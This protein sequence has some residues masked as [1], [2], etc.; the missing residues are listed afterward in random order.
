MNRPSK[1]MVTAAAW[2][3]ALSVLSGCVSITAPVVPP[4]GGIYTKTAAPLILPQS[5]MAAVDLRD[6]SAEIYH[7]KIPIDY[8]SALS[9]LSAIS[10]TWDR[11][12]L[13]KVVGPTP[14]ERIAFADYEIKSVLGVY[15]EMKVTVYG[16]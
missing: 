14:F 12:D 13:E 6:C 2:S 15:A 16:Q 4:M 9:G 8:A 11:A 3:L 10:F 7:I 5:G 1:R